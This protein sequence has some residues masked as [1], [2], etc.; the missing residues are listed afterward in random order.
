MEKP[1]VCPS[2]LSPGNGRY[3]KAALIELF[4]GKQ[5]DIT[6]DI[7][8]EKDL[9]SSSL[10]D[11]MNNMSISG[12][13]EK[14][15]AIATDGK[16]R[17]A[18]KGE[19]GT[20]ILKPP[21]YN[22]S[23]LTRRQIPANEH[24]TMQIAGQVYGI[25]TA[26]NGLCFDRR[27]QEVYITKRFDF[28]PDGTRCQI[29]DFASILGRAEE[30]NGSG[31]KYDGSYDMIANAIKNVVP[32]WQANVEKLFKMI[33]FSYMFANED[34]H[35]K[36]FSLIN[37]KG[38]Y[39]MAPAYDLINTLIHIESGSD[40]GL[41]GGLSPNIPKT[42]VY[43]RS[44]HPARHDFEMFAQH[45]GLPETRIDIILDKY[46]VIGPKVYELIDNSFLN[47]KMK[48]NYIK[49]I[50]ERNARFVRID[51][52]EIGNSDTDRLMKEGVCT[53]IDYAK[54]KK[55][56]P[57]VTNILNRLY[58]KF[59]EID[60]YVDKRSISRHLLN[61]SMQKMNEVEVSKAKSA[62]VLALSKIHTKK[63]LTIGY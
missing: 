30:N 18:A 57:W 58:T 14:F 38:E 16:I 21:P 33:V 52:L 48:R 23:L 10:R 1:K 2:K 17:L 59:K 63:D 62:L 32:S 28:N 51:R 53:L 47:D 44:G 60:P 27:G 39:T 37:R 3:S 11:N 15:S 36:N 55:G 31:F 40:F 42:D 49:T 34:A 4:E 13:Q 43:K 20:H 6:I 54:D 61:L 45:I 41:K 35:L 46:M 50:Q 26:Y 24:L 12:A 5:T 25:E 22:Y 56:Q 9:D 7:D 19:Q 8:F 29:E